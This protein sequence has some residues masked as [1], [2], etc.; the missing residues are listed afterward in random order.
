VIGV[1]VSEDHGGDRVERP[2]EL[3][4][5]GGQLLEIPREAAIDDCDRAVDVEEVPAN[6]VRPEPVHAI[7]DLL[8]RGHRAVTLARI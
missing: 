5:R 3:R 6:P 4:Q 1:V 2:A 7:C 8:D